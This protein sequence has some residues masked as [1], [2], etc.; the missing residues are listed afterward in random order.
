M[1]ARCLPHLVRE[2]PVAKPHAV[3]FMYDETTANFNRDVKPFSESHN[4]GLRSGRLTTCLRGVSNGPISR[5]SVGSFEDHNA[6][7]MSQHA[8]TTSVFR[9]SQQCEFSSLYFMSRIFF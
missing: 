9:L 6:L 8:G 1:P 4:A 7:Q 3:G 5:L 2:A